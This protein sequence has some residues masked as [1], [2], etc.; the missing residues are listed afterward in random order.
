MSN[1][2]SSPGARLPIEDRMQLIALQVLAEAGGPSGALSL[3]SA[4]RNAGIDI[5]EATAGRFLRQL[6]ELGY[7]RSL[8]KR[9]R[10][11]TD[12]GEGRLSQLQLNKSLAAHGARV[13]AAVGNNDIDQLI[14][15]LHVRRAV[16]AE[17]A[18]LAAARAT[19]EE[20]DRIAHAATMHVHCVEDDNRVE[21]SQNFHALVSTYS[22]NQML[23]AMTA[24]LLDPQ[25]DPLAKLL[26]RIADT[27]GTVLPMAIDHEEIAKA[28]QERDSAKSE[29]LMR[30]HIDKLIATVMHYRDLR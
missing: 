15:L 19:P 29:Q 22:H 12:M 4:F 7:T 20:I 27:S 5:A 23:G 14:D 8:G 3:V 11:L 1:T 9:G 16:E 13:T 10:V 25:H 2:E 28:I 30:V 17:A 21:L 24:M 26:D 6:D 18:G